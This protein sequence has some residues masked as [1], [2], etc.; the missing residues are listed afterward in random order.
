MWST[1]WEADV[2]GILMFS[3]FFPRKPFRNKNEL[4]AALEAL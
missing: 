1:S 2:S 3:L 4:S